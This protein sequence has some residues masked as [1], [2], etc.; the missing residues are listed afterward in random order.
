MF[1]LPFMISAMRKLVWAIALLTVQQA[2][3]QFGEPER[4]LEVGLTLCATNYS[5]DLAPDHISLA[6]TRVGTGAFARV[7]LSHF[8][9]VRGQLFAGRLY[10]D[11][12]H[13]PEHAGRQFRFTA[14]LFEGAAL[15]EATLGTF[16]YEPVRADATYY[17]SPYLFAG[18]GATLVNPQVTY[19]GPEDRRARF[20]RE[21]I[22]EGGQSRRTL[23]TTPFGAGLRAFAGG[24]FGFGLEVGI[25]PVYSDL[26]DGVS[27]NG[28]P[29]KEDWYYTLGATVSYFVGKPWRAKMR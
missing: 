21:P 3:A 6:Q 19:Y 28:N 15:L 9:Q 20:V 2:Q 5:G 16:Q 17:F 27:V 26:L 18:V 7:H 13:F 12:K 29:E 11:D 4:Y 24:R 1:L 10:G 22:P 14:N 8:F 25:R 23:L